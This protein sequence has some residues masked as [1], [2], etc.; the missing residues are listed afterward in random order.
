[1]VRDGEAAHHSGDRGGLLRGDR[2][3]GRRPPP[4]KHQR[5]RPRPR[6]GPV[7]R[8]VRSE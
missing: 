5:Y 6:V 3:E 8:L 7:L 1:M 2:N 4:A